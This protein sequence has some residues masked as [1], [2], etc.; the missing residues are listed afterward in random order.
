MYTVG[1]KGKKELLDTV[2]LPEFIRFSHTQRYQPV[3]R[4]TSSSSSTSGRSYGEIRADTHSGRLFLLLSLAPYIYLLRILT[5][6]R[7]SNSTLLVVLIQES[8]YIVAALCIEALLL[9]FLK[10]LARYSIFI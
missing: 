10:L 3:Y 4:L 8:I 6:N 7:R 1:A 2:A 5:R 9:L